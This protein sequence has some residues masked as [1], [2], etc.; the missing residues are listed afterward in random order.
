MTRSGANEVYGNPEFDNDLVVSPA[1]IN[2]TDMLEAE[3]V[4][5]EALEEEPVDLA[6]EA[7]AAS[8]LFMKAKTRFK[9]VVH[10]RLFYK[11]NDGS[12]SGSKVGGRGCFASRGGCVA[13]QPGESVQ[14]V[15]NQT[16]CSICGN[17]GHWRG[18]PG[19]QGAPPGGIPIGGRGCGG[20][21]VNKTSTP[22]IASSPSAIP[23]EGYLMFNLGR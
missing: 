9:K 5:P 7:M 12:R 3:I 17:R 4:S 23:N 2:V 8:Q 21:S 14:E 13:R 18:D 6:N 1:Q 20:R 10:A 11:S 15:K 22:L 19:S 16:T